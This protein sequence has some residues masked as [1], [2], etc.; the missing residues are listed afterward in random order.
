MQFVWG[1]SC[2]LVVTTVA[3]HLILSLWLLVSTLSDSTPIKRNV[4]VSLRELP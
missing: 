1:I 2:A 4:R 3:Q